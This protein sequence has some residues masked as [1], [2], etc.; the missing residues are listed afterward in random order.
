MQGKGHV[1]LPK[2]TFSAAK[3]DPPMPIASVCVGVEGLHNLCRRT[4]K[5]IAGVQSAM[6]LK[7]FQCNVERIIP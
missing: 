5:S 3:S 2:S 6:D 1:P 7:A 4:L